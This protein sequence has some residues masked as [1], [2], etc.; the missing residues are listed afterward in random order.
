MGDKRDIMS[1]DAAFNRKSSST[2]NLLVVYALRKIYETATKVYVIQ[3]SFASA[4]T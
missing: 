2:V 3:Y 1:V 4:S